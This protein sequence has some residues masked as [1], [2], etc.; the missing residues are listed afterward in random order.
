MRN[1]RIQGALRYAG[2]WKGGHMARLTTGGRRADRIAVDGATVRELLRIAGISQAELARRIDK[3]PETVGRMARD[4][5]TRIEYVA[6]LAIVTGIDGARVDQ[7]EGLHAIG[8]AWRAIAK[9][10]A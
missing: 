10:S 2:F 1:Y 3:N 8:E 4:G 7:I 6:L 5:A 9:K